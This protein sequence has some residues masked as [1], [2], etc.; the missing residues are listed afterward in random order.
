VFIVILIVL[1]L[2]LCTQAFSANLYLNV[3]AVNGTE[4]ERKKKLRAVL[5]REL[6]ADDII[7]TDGLR[8]EYDVEAAAYVVTGDIKLG[9]KETKTY[10]IL[11]RDLW[12]FDQ[13]KVNKIFEQ[14]E[15]SLKQLEETEY[16][17][18]GKIKQQVLEQR[19][20]FLLQE[21]VRHADNI[22]KRIDTYRVY[23]QEFEVLREKAASIKYWRAKLPNFGDADIF[24]FII[25]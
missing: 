5:P 10:K 7:D 17:K 25:E 23:V 8:L 6:T 2:L 11:I 3:V 20:D 13:K 4:E 24:Y 16:Y 21:Q 18:A 1:N 9:P 12:Q 19:L 22:E 15:I 14:I